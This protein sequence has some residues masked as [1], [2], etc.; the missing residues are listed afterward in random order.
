MGSPC[1]QGRASACLHL[2]SMFALVAACVAGALPAHALASTGRVAPGSAARSSDRVIELK[3]ADG[4]AT[5]ADG[6]ALTGPGAASVEATLA[7]YGNSSVERLFDRDADTLRRQWTRLRSAHGV[8]DLSQYYRVVFR[9][10]ADTD[11][12]A[13]ALRG[14]PQVA[15]AY[16]EPLP[17]PAPSTPDFAGNQLYGASAPGGIDFANIDRVQVVAQRTS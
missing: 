7:R 16:P 15:E 12:A 1:R 3:L 5:Q 4:G 10:G 14:L 2:R 9:D 8:A 11:A 13:A 6:G 17:A